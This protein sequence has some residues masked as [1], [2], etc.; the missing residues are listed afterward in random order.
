[1]THTCTNQGCFNLIPDWDPHTLC[2]F[3]RSCNRESPCVLCVG[4]SSVHF[5]QLKRATSLG[6]R[7][8]SKSGRMVSSTGPM[9][10]STSGGDGLGPRAPVQV[11]VSDPS[12][13]SV[14]VTEA[15]TASSVGRQ[16]LRVDPGLSPSTQPPSGSGVTG[17]K[18][19]VSSSDF[20]H[21]GLVKGVDPGLGHG[22]LALV[23]LSAESRPSV[24]VSETPGSCRA[25]V[26]DSIAPTSMP[27]TAVASEQQLPAA[28]QPA[29]VAGSLAA[30]GQQQAGET[31]A[32]HARHGDAAV[33]AAVA[34]L[35]SAGASQL[36]MAAGS[37]ALA[38]QQPAI[39]AV[40]RAPPIPTAPL[41]ASAT[42][43]A[44]GVTCVQV[45]SQLVTSVTDTMASA[46]SAPASVSITGVAPRLSTRVVDS[47]GTYAGMMAGPGWPVGYPGL[48]Q[49]AL[50]YGQGRH[51]AHAGLLP[52]VSRPP[53]GLGMP[54]PAVTQ[55]LGTV[56]PGQV[57][58]GYHAL[59][60]QRL[61]LGPRPTGVQ[62]PQSQ[63]MP[64]ALGFGASVGLG[65][66][67]PTA[68]QGLGP[69][70]LDP[71]WQQYGLTGPRPSD[72]GG[73]LGLGTQAAMASSF[74]LLH[75]LQQRGGDA[76]CS[77]GSSN[78]H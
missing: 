68:V 63:P 43:L 59:G 21:P 25:V 37:E 4:F 76:G 6:L 26:A 58:S 27:A 11:A 35:S 34:G 75:S 22:G 31:V 48:S 77:C 16:P 24:T 78:G 30:T 71:M 2:V 61:G 54:A 46:W 19:G 74:N 15:G 45:A 18:A 69:F 42:G 23:G 5:D 14:T 73:W 12:N 56:D 20:T 53:P 44:A 36:A 29:S 3:H 64:P 40:P 17:G 10:N 52:Q 47:Q 13:G 8:R 7:V 50:A 62:V 60:T 49:H 1:M 65:G 72:P 66:L 32:V 55:G 28:E 70:G 57:A 51:P 41:V 39:A 9:P 38:G 33:T 67:G